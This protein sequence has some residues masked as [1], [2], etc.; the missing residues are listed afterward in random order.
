[1]V[2]NSF[3][4]CGR[5]ASPES[6]RSKFVVVGLQDQLGRSPYFAAPS[7]HVQSA[8][9]ELNTTADALKTRRIAYAATRYSTDIA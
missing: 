9:T 8:F 7:L 3:R 1:M 5:G 6:P 2:K 4:T